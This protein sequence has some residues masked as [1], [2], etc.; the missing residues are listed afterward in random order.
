MV[1]LFVFYTYIVTLV[2]G[3][4]VSASFPRGWHFLLLQH[5]SSEIYTLA[6]KRLDRLFKERSEIVPRR[7]ARK[8]SGEPAATGAAT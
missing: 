3:P 7:N 8:F 2:P 5:S 6:L 1:I 4:E